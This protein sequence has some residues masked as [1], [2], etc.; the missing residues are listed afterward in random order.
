[1]KISVLNWIDWEFVEVRCEAQ[2]GKTAAE[3]GDAVFDQ[4][5]AALALHGLDLSNTIR[6]RVFGVD[7]PARD[8]VS[9]SRF[10]ALKGNDR[11]ASSSYIAPKHF[12]SKALV[13]L[14]LIAVRPRPGVSKIIKEYV[15]P[16]GPICYIAM[17]PL[18]VL[19]GNTSQLPTLEEQVTT[20]I[21]PRIDLYLKEGASSWKQ[22]VNVSCYMH[23]SQKP[24]ELRTHFKTIADPF[25]VRFEIYFV[26]GFSSP[27]KLVEVEVT[28]RR[29]G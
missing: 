9:N 23:E 18:L 3:Q 5:R 4:A 10:A 7:R 16:K 26:E 19:S 2:S 15:P 29:N 13:A 11:A 17:G 14:D 25:P 27:D 24:D 21:L 1:M 6:S 20:D 8:A 12:S 28:A 22:V